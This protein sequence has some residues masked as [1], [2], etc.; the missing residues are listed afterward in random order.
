[1]LPRKL[2]SYWGL[3]TVAKFVITNGRVGNSY[4]NQEFVTHAYH[5]P[6]GRKALLRKIQGLADRSGLE[7]W[8]ELYTEWKDENRTG[9]TPNRIFPRKPYSTY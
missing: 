8:A 4:G 1:M 7:S 2:R 6:M 3:F 5:H 9:K